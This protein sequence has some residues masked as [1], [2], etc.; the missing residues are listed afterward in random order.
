MYNA[1]EEIPSIQ[2]LVQI[3]VREYC[4]EEWNYVCNSNYRVITYLD[5]HIKERQFEGKTWKHIAVEMVNHLPQKVYLSFDIDGFDAS[6]IPATGT[7]E[8]GGIFWYDAISIIAAAAK[9]CN[10]VG[11]DINELAPIKGMHACD[12]LAAKLAYKIISL[13]FLKHKIGK[14]Y[15]SLR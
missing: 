7:P 10:I 13:V 14:V 5:Q 12:F 1:L 9:K 6:M 3:G 15:D 11:A 4:E 2:K 8:P